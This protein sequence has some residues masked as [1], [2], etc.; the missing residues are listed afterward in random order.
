MDVRVRTHARRSRLIPRIIFAPLRRFCL[1]RR[2]RF[3]NFDV[4]LYITILNILLLLLYESSPPRPK[5]ARTLQHLYN[6]LHNYCS[7]VFIRYKRT[8]IS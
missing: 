8:A 6:M 4:L 3:V 5:C 1:F 7:P 2:T